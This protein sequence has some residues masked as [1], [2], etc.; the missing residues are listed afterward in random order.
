MHPISGGPAVLVPFR[1]LFV[2]DVD[3][4][5]GTLDLLAGWLLE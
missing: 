2:G 4:E 5:A 3:L 1:K